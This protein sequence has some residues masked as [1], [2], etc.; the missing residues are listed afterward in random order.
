MEQRT[1]DV[2][3]SV[4]TGDVFMSSLVQVQPFQVFQTFDSFYTA[5]L[6]HVIEIAS[7]MVS[8]CNL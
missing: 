2:W 8:V 6:L 5:K 4:R 3:K 1:P 7:K